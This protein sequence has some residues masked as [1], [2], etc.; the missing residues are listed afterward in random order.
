MAADKNKNEIKLKKEK[1]L[2][3]D[4]RQV[5]NVDNPRKLWISYHSVAFKKD[6]KEI[7]SNRK[8][9]LLDVF[10][11][12]VDRVDPSRHVRPELAA[13]EVVLG[14]VELL[15]VDVVVASVAPAV[16]QAETSFW[17]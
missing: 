5:Q 6:R 10:L 7:I 13:V 14:R 16:D 4:S 17:W 15:V 2:F 8:K 3:G 12:D 1:F 11:L 9:P